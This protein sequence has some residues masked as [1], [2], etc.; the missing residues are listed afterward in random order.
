MCVKGA[1]AIAVSPEKKNKKKKQWKKEKET[2]VRRK[3]LLINWS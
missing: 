3:N 2:W 1:K